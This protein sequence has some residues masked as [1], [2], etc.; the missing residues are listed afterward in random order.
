MLPKVAPLELRHAT[1][2]IDFSIYV[3][4]QKRHH[5]KLVLYNI[6]DSL[7]DIELPSN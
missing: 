6:Y 5:C 2:A 7:N 3:D 1:I 4:Y